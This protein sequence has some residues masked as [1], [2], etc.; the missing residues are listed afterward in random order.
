MVTKKY[1]QRSMKGNKI[2]LPRLM[3]HSYKNLK[4]ETAVRW[5][6]TKKYVCLPKTKFPPFHHPLATAKDYKGVFRFKQ[7]KVKLNKCIFLI[8]LI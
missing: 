6:F 7:K 2:R 1:V 4:V 3:R 8:L 5:S